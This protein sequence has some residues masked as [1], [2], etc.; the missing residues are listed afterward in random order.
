M[1]EFYLGELNWCRVK[2]RNWDTMSSS[3]A[4]AQSQLG[5]LGLITFSQQTNSE[6][7]EKKLQGLIQ[8]VTSENQTEFKRRKII[9]LSPRKDFLMVRSVQKWNILL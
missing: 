6:N 7:L 1:P 3:P 4:L 5:D 9:H 2:A 8:A